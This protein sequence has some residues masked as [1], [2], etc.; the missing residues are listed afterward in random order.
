MIHLV[1]LGIVSSRS[2]TSASARLGTAAYVRY[3]A[4]GG[5][6]EP[7]FE[8]DRAARCKAVRN[9][10]AEYTPRPQGKP[11]L[12]ARTCDPAGRSGNQRQ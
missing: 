4:D 11:P 3:R 6:V 2:A 8:A 10:D 12:I 1:T 5:I 9:A 7:A